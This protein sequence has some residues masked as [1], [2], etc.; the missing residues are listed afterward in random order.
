MNMFDLTDRVAVVTGTANG[1]G[2]A[3]ATVFAE[4]GAHVVLLDIDTVGNEATAHNLSQLG[5]RSARQ[6]PCRSAHRRGQFAH[7]STQPNVRNSFKRFYFH[8]LF[9]FDTAFCERQL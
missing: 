8:N 5:Y 2:Q 4:N 9:Q 3:M 1:M 7:S 6:T